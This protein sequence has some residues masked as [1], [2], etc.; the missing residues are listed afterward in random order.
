VKRFIN[1]VVSCPKGRVVRIVKNT[2]DLL[3]DQA[4]K[5]PSWA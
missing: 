1:I 4:I 3:A 5:L 2:L